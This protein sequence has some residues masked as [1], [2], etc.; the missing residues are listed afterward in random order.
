M[1]GL[2]TEAF[3]FAEVVSVLS[4]ELMEDCYYFL[5]WGCSEEPKTNSEEG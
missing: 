3:A 5:L 4:I 2:V 1:A